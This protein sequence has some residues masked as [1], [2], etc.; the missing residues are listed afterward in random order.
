MLTG[1]SG[2]DVRHDTTCKNYEQVGC[3]MRGVSR[4]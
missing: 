4:S 2:D 1:G 3:T